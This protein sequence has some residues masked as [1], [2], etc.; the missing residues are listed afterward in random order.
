MQGIC[1]FQG[2]P[3]GT[4]ANYW[5]GWQTTNDHLVVTRRGQGDFL[6]V[7]LNLQRWA[8]FLAERDN[9]RYDIKDATHNSLVPSLHGI[10]L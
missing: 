9:F 5:K 3:G 6:A 4:Q 2:P 7:Q 8:I 1:G 10:L